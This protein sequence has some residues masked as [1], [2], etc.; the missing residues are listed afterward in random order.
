M[1]TTTASSSCT[2]L[3]SAC[4]VA[5]AQ[6]TQPDAADVPLDVMGAIVPALPRG[7]QAVTCCAAGGRRRRRQAGAV[8]GVGHASPEAGVPGEQ[9]DLGPVGAAQLHQE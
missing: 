7:G 8:D 5:M 1:K 9:V 3:A 4:P 6:K 2:T